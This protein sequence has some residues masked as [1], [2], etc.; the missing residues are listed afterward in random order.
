[1]SDF[2]K[3]LRAGLVL[4]GVLVCAA[5]ASEAQASEKKEGP[6]SLSV[7]ITNLTLPLLLEDRSMVGRL[8]LVLDV[9]ATDAAAVT[10]IEE[11]LP[12]IRDLLLTR[13]TPTPIP[14]SSNVSAE[15][16]TDMK[17]RILALLREVV[18]ADA[19]RAVYIVKA[20]TRR[21]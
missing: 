12:R 8:D 20:M 6:V 15:T 19:V 10:R 9:Q 2:V 14:G 17:S 3:F 11:Q 7:P 21:S 5:P 1:M 16:L 18:G 4:A 13:V